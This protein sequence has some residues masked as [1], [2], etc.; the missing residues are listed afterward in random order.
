MTRGQYLT[1]AAGAPRRLLFV[2]T[3]GNGGR[4]AAD[5]RRG[6]V[7]WGIVRTGPRS[8]TTGL[9]PTPVRDPRTREAREREGPLGLHGMNSL[10]PWKPL[11]WAVFAAAAIGVPATGALAGGES[12]PSSFD[13]A[14]R[15]DG[16]TTMSSHV[17][18]HAS[19]R[20]TAAAVSGADG[21][22][23]TADAE[24]VTR[25]GSV[26]RREEDHETSLARAPDC[27]ASAT[28]RAAVDVG[29]DD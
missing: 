1:R 15:H 18:S 29:D 5:S 28:A 7:C 13:N 4:G 11:L 17:S 8:S 2:S 19:A 16:G 3:G 22:R 10:P 6:P 23:A 12:W 14:V 25:V 9:G 24:A 21:C 27:S 26:T 20:A